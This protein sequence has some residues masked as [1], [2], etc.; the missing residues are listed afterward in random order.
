MFDLAARAIESGQDLRL[1]CRELSRVVRDM[2]VIN[3]DPSRADEPDFAPEG[4]VERLKALTARFSRE[5]LLRAFDVIARAEFEIRTAAQ[6]RYHLEMAL[7]RW[8]H[9]RKVQPLA[10]VL[11]ALGRAAHSLPSRTRSPRDARMPPATRRRASERAPAPARPAAPE[12]RQL[13]RRP[14]LARAC[15]HPRPA[16]P[17]SAGAR[18]RPSARARPRQPAPRGDTASPSRNAGA[19]PPRPPPRSGRHSSS[20]SARRKVLHGTVLAQAQRIDLDGDV[21]TF[22]FGPQHRVLRKQVDETRG[23]LEQIADDVA[24]RP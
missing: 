8:I 23:V 17:T 5:D 24:G 22:S 10:E 13:R 21:L 3:I 20:R 15:R 11:Q 7:L 12:R 14:R 4:D 9:L 18:H 2:M 19:G 6:P 16:R 1:L